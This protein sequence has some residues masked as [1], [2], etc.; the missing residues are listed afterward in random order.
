MP[1]LRLSLFTL[2]PS[3]F[4]APAL[5]AAP[6]ASPAVAAENPFGNSL[7]PDLLADPA[8]SEVN[9]VF[10]CYATTDG[11]GQGL[12]TSGTP[13]VWKSRDFLNW[14]FDG[15]SF[16]PDFDLKYWA[17]SGIVPHGGKFYSYPTLDG[18]ITAVVAD[19]P[20]GIFTAPDGR[21]V[22]RADGWRPFP[23]PQKS[24]IDAEIFTDDDRETYMIWSRRRMVKL[25]PDLLAADGPVIA[26]P[27]KRPGYTEGPIFFKR[28]GAYYY[29]YTL[30]GGLT[31]QYAYMMNR[32]SPRGPWE[33]PRDDLIATS[34]PANGVYG[35]G[36]GCV[37]NPQG[38]DDWYFVFLE[39]GRGGTNRAIYAARMFFNAD[40]TIQPIKVTNQGV[41]AIR[42]TTEPSPNL[43]LGATATASSTR[44]DFDM[45]P[46]FK[47]ARIEH[48]APA[49]AIDGSNGSRWMAAEGDAAPWFQ[50]DLGAPRDIHRTEA[51]F[52]KPAAGHAY[53]LESS[54]D[55]KTWQP[56]GGHADLLRKSPH[57]DTK[58]VR[59]RYLRLTILKGEPGL[60]EFR[61]Y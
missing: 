53:R 10:Y 18:Q 4:A 47:I 22:T 6:A 19:S 45:R 13:V 60:W 26:L 27:T 58:S 25:K 51:Y 52:V 2:L 31:Y 42:P 16:P 59:A 14:S 37:F 12:K 48:F 35:P 57:T 40:G 41:G 44:A 46:R 11:W 23:I 8:I 7:I 17:P 50:V 36:H 34:D 56:Y 28:Q 49:N 39:F 43:A 38:T 15:S 33:A 9:G 20:T 54:L 29:L 30:G 21:H 24:S 55:G 1:P 32:H 61:V 3:L 5:H